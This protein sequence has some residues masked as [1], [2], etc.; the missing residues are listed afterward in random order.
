M[1]VIASSLHMGFISFY[2]RPVLVPDNRIGNHVHYEIDNIRFVQPQ[3]MV[4]SNFPKIIP[5]AINDIRI[6]L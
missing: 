1:C 4:C 6:S 5:T 3:Q 2:H